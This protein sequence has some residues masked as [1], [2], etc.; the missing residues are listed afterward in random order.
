[1]KKGVSKIPLADVK[2]M[3]AEEGIEVTDEEI[4]GI[5]EFLHMLALIVLKE[6]FE[7]RNE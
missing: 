1:M 6:S 7:K 2:A 3:L 5:I 4:Q